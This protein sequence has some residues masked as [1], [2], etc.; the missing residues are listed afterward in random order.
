MI[1]ETT[2]RNG[3]SIKENLIKLGLEIQGEEGSSS[4]WD[5]GSLLWAIR[6]IRLDIS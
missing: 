4:S 6:D 2:Y 1:D 3:S 5:S